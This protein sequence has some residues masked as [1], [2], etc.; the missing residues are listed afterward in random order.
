MND[1]CDHGASR[2]SMRVVKIGKQNDHNNYIP[3]ALLLLLF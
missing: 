1:P 2:R 3:A